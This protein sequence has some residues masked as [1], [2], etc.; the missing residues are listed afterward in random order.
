LE[1]IILEARR[2]ISNELLDTM[3][4]CNC[5]YY[6]LD[7]RL[8]TYLN[9]FHKFSDRQLENSYVWH[10]K[11]SFRH[12]KW[13]WM[14]TKSIFNISESVKEIDEQ[15]RLHAH[16]DLLESIVAI[17][18]F[19]SIFDG[20]IADYNTTV[21]R[22][23]STWIF[24]EG[25]VAHLSYLLTCIPQVDLDKSET[26]ARLSRCLV[27]AIAVGDSPDA[28]KMLL[29]FGADR[30]MKVGV[31]PLTGQ[32]S[33]EY[34][35]YVYSDRQTSEEKNLELTLMDAYRLGYFRN[36]KVMLPS[37]FPSERSNLSIFNET[38]ELQFPAKPRDEDMEK[39]IRIL[40][41]YRPTEEQRLASQLR[42]KVRID[43]MF[44]YGSRYSRFPERFRRQAIDERYFS[45]WERLYPGLRGAVSHGQVE[46]VRTMYPRLPA[47]AAGS[48]LLPIHLMSH[49][50][51]GGYAGCA[52]VVD[53]LSDLVRGLSPY[54]TA[55]TSLHLSACEM[56]VA[57]G[58]D[59]REPGLFDA[60]LESL[61]TFSSLATSGSSHRL[62]TEYPAYTQGYP[63]AQSC[64]QV[65]S[66]A[67]VPACA[68]TVEVAK[69]RLKD[70]MPEAFD[71]LELMLYNGL[72]P[73]PCLLRPL[74]RL[75]KCKHLSSE[76]K[77]ALVSVIECTLAEVVQTSRVLSLIQVLLHKFVWLDIDTLIDFV[78]IFL[79]EE[80]FSI[81]KEHGA[82]SKDIADLVSQASCSIEAASA[83]IQSR[84]SYIVLAIL[85][86][87]VRNSKAR[88]AS[89]TADDDNTVIENRR[90]HS[91][92]SNGC[93]EVDKMVKFL[94]GKH[95]IVAVMRP[96]SLI[97]RPLSA[98][99]RRLNE[100]RLG[101]ESDVESNQLG[102]D[103]KGT[104]ACSESENGSYQA[105]M[106]RGAH[107]V[108]ALGACVDRQEEE[109]KQLHS[110][111]SPPPNMAGRC[112]RERTSQ[113]S[114]RAPLEGCSDIPVAFG[115]QMI[116]AMVILTI[117]P[118]ILYSMS[119]ACN[120]QLTWRLAC[121]T[122]YPM[123]RTRPAAY[124]V[125]PSASTAE[126]C[127]RS[128]L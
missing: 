27:Y 24:Q 69:Q 97:D 19:F 6:K 34:L 29:D 90:L 110:G 43:S 37:F 85:E 104:V 28:V 18:P 7:R 21:A 77:Q 89:I 83:A 32:T 101:L 41:D 84:D 117:I 52:Q 127:V 23:C 119:R 124:R 125:L 118:I 12:E 45:I 39:R 42:C 115:Q 5:S 1:T 73:T 76:E 116:M 62:D 22:R 93:F 20:R 63:S 80:L 121:R 15:I 9:V 95:E 128:T 25:S 44:E 46:L 92:L 72:D 10:S 75:C 11:H 31:R 14:G 107:D 16:K 13:L 112:C 78:Q 57:R 122:S 54:T 60:L 50:G 49:A 96:P 4:R 102:G 35:G 58:H 79:D 111:P 68:L 17:F 99:D 126:L 113:E 70:L 47:D 40:Y 53:H 48:A 82:D 36:D 114:P 33:V 71:A 87:I 91:S 86:R 109:G 67:H 59:V 30:N 2:A 88:D 94:V 120:S 123:T 38:N 100:G 74:H 8:Y 103:E 98:Q 55:A 3:D 56:L 108:A 26:K 106:L 64:L 51:E 81:A 61:M 65:G 66:S 105:K